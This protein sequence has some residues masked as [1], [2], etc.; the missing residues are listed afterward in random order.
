MKTKVLYAIP[1]LALLLAMPMGAS[2]VK[3]GATFVNWNLSGAVMPSPP[4]GLH[5]IIGSDTS[6][7]LILNQP[8]GAVS[9]MLTGAMNGLAP[10]TLYTVYISNSYTT[11]TVAWS[12]NGAW[13]LAFDSTLYPGGNPYMH[14]MTVTGGT[15]TGG[16]PAGG[17]YTNS[18]TATVSV[19]GNAVTIVATYLL[20]SATYPYSFT[21]TG[22]ISSAGTLSGTWTDTLGDSGTWSLTS[23][24]ANYIITSGTGYPGL[25]YGVSTF[26][27][28]TDSTGSGSWHINLPAADFTGPTGT[29]YGLSVWI[30][31]PFP[32]TIL[33]SNNF[34]V[35]V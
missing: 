35:T 30:N 23:G 27:F 22:T 9:V 10:N 24:N 33:I 4:W 17:P 7:K 11:T 31:S 26:T 2:A 15:A 8:N 14:D 6:S 28:M 12:L 19:S 3:P 20:G 1:L 16:W 32:A 18:W 25:F 34:Q 5:D 13:K 21:A 29:I